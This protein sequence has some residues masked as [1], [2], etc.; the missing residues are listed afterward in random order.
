VIHWSPKTL[1]GGSD[2][3]IEA[4]ILAT[5]KLDFSPKGESVIR[6]SQKKPSNPPLLF[7]DTDNNNSSKLI[8][9]SSIDLY[10]KIH[11][12]YF[13]E[14]TPHSDPEVRELADQIFQNIRQYSLYMVVA[15]TPIFPCVKILEWIIHHANVE[16]F[17]LNNKYG[18]CIG[19]L[20]LTEVST[21]YKLKDVE[22]RLNKSFLW[23]YMNTIIMVNFYH[24]SGGRIINL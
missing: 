22:V 19:V 6:M 24:L 1:K 7:K 20:L 5:K 8:L 21:Y 3:I 15:K 9:P 16:K 12:E 11:Y 2:K 18:E 17:L 23:N 14:F 4:S 10:N 13:P